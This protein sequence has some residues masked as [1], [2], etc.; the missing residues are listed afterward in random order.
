VPASIRHLIDSAR[1]ATRDETGAALWAA[2]LSAPRSLPA[3]YLLYKFHAA[4]GELAHAQ[5]VAIKALAVAAEQASLARDW[6]MVRASDAD[7]R[8]PAPPA[9]G[10]SR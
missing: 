8:C 1:G 6:R 9:S 10:C 5:Q 3:Y 4:A 2:V 7:F